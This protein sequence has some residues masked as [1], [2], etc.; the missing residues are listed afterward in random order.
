MKKYKK[1]LYFVPMLV[2]MIV[3]FSFSTQPAK[4][5]DMN[6]SFVITELQKIGIDLTVIFGKDLANFL[7]RKAAHLTEYVIL[8]LLSYLGLCKNGKR[9]RLLPLLIVFLYAG[10]DE[11]H[12]MFVPGRSGMFRDVLIDTCGGTIGLLL[13]FIGRKKS[14]GVR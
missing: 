13:T 8:Y 1:L 9:N 5:S 3:I 4:L 12:Q 6:N 14:G 11:I 10:S 7:I 2:W